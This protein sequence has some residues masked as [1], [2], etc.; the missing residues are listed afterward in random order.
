MALPAYWE[1]FL[2]YK[3]NIFDIKFNSEDPSDVYALT[4]Y[5]LNNNMSTY[6]TLTESV[7]IPKRVSNQVDTSIHDIKKRKKTSKK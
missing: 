2:E 3:M 4:E 1:Q 7:V 5:H 6:F